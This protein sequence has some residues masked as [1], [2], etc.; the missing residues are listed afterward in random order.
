M[1]SVSLLNVAVRN[2]PA[3]FNAAYEFE[4][5]FECLEPL[6]KDLEWKLTYVGS[7]TSSDHD[8]ELDSLLVGPIPVGVNKFVFEADPP[9]TAHIPATEILGVTVIL[10]TCSYDEREFVRVGYY[11]NNEYVDETLANEPPAKPVLEKIK[12]SILAEKPRVTRFAIKWD[13]EESAPAEFPPEQNDVDE[14]EE[15][16]VNYGAEEEEEG[17]EEEGEEAPELAEGE[18]TATKKEVG[19]DADMEGVEAEKEDDDGSEDLEEESEDEEDLEDE[20]GEEEVEGEGEANGGD[21]EME[22]DHDAPT[23]PE[24]PTAQHQQADVMV[25]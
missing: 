25:H 8:Q 5:T 1:A 15:D 19:E 13:S 22:M 11:V 16:G 7:A 10:L 17:D 3:P 4:I 20:E 12:R 2:N 18:A 14:Q 21:H 24:Q 9:N 6:A 23:K